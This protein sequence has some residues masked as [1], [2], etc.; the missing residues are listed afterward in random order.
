VNALDLAAV[1]QKLNRPA[2]I[3]DPADVN[4]DG[5]VNAL[6]LGLVKANL[7]R[8][9]S[10]LVVPIPAVPLVL[11]QPSDP[12]LAPAH[13]WDEQPADLLA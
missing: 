8:S 3:D 7:N 6:D 13:L 12:P 10:P 5:R 11:P 2:T 4:R 1:K 9:L